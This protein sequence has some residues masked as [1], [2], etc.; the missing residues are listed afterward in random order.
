ML[1]ECN[2]IFTEVFVSERDGSRYVDGVDLD[3]GGDLSLVFE[4]GQD[5]PP[6]SVPLQFRATVRGKRWGKA[7][8]LRVQQW[9]G[10]K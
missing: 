3:A 10:G 7:Y 8:R 4:D 9:A 5:V 6:L 2:A 1:L